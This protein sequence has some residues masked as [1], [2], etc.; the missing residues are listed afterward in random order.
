MVRDAVQRHVP[1]AELVQAHPDLGSEAV[2]LLEPGVAVTRRTSPG[3]AGPE[4][5]ADQLRRFHE[6]LLHD[7][8]RLGPE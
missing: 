7:E 8:E 2:A 6:R 3:A 5:V 1:L 4:A